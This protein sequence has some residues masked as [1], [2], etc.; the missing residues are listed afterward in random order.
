MM[1]VNTLLYTLLLLL[2][3]ILTTSPFDAHTMPSP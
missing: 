1:L 3:F 2:A